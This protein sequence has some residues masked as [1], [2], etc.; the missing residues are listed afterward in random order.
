[1]ARA[2]VHAAIRARSE[3][4]AADLDALIALLAEHTETLNAVLALEA[5]AVDQGADHVTRPN[6]NALGN[7]ARKFL[8][9]IERSL[10]RP[11]L[12]S[13][14]D[15]LGLWGRNGHAPAIAD[16]LRSAEYQADCGRVVLGR[17]AAA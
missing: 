3:T 11:I 4:D 2:D 16:M 15:D 14:H 10:N 5:A 13:A 17:R 9:Q 1:M 12:G 6:L 8:R 7:R